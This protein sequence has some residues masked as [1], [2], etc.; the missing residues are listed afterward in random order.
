MA[1]TEP[2]PYGPLVVPGHARLIVAA[3][4]CPAG[5]SFSLSGSS[6]TCGRSGDGVVL[7]EDDAVSPTHCVF[8]YDDGKLSVED[9]GSLNGVYVRTQGPTLVSHGDW[10][11]VGDQYF[12]FDELTSETEFP[13]DEG[14]LF[15]TSP[16]R[17]GSFRIL[18]MLEGGKT[19]LSSTTSNDEVTVGG[20]GAA[21]AFT[22]DVH[23]S[24]LHV[25][26]YKNS[27]GSFSI[28]DLDSVNGTYVRIGEKTA[29]AHGDFVFVGNTLLRVEIV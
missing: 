19:G 10:F 12:R 7:R 23:L 16:R 8:S 6:H 24:K 22:S 29:L 18:Q 27:T 15:F 25:K 13:N 4:P 9:R 11:R 26:I 14:T 28:E 21:V 1:A 2:Q 3:G 20:E 5:M 17:K